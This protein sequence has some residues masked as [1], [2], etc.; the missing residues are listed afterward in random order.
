MDPSLAWI[1][2]Y[3]GTGCGITL[4]Y[5]LGRLFGLRGF[6]GIGRLFHVSPARVAEA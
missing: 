1:T 5:L 3:L 6:T 4:S 2:D